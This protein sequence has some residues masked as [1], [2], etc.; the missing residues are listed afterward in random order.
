MKNCQIK[1]WLIDGLFSISYFVYFMMYSLTGKSMAV[2]GNCAY[3][4]EKTKLLGFFF[5]FFW[6]HFSLHSYKALTM[7][8][9]LNSSL[10][11]KWKG[12][13][14]WAEYRQAEKL[15]TVAGF[16]SLRLYCQILWNSQNDAVF[17]CKP[18]SAESLSFYICNTH[19]RL[20]EDLSKIKC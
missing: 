13:Q 19:C 12:I 14:H 10:A 15:P 8:S 11:D 6:F 18:S 1:T 20:G 3:I 17:T 4:K 9:F 16:L 2:N 7:C 5:F